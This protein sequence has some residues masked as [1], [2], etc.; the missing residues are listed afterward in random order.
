M[1]PKDGAGELQRRLRHFER[2][3]GVDLIIQGLEERSPGEVRGVLV[4]DDSLVIGGRVVSG[5]VEDIPP[6]LAEELQLILV[7]VVALDDPVHLLVVQLHERAVDL[8]DDA[9]HIVA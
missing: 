1:Q 4:G 7:D 6:Q 9:G 3:E 2:P 5:L 8:A